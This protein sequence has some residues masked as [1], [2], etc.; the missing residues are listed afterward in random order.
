MRPEPGPLNHL[1]QVSSHPPLKYDRKNDRRTNQK[2]QKQSVTAAT[3]P[4]GRDS[5]P[6][7]RRNK[8]H[9]LSLSDTLEDPDE[10]KDEEK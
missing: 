9:P 6:G 8:V 5:E 7:D 4:P 3:V 2:H 10:D 1:Q